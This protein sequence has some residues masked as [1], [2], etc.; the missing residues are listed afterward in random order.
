LEGDGKL[1]RGGTAA[2]N[3]LI[4]NG[5]EFI[6][7]LSQLGA[8]VMKV[9]GSQVSASSVVIAGGAIELTTGSAR[10]MGQAFMSGGKLLVS[11]NTDI[12]ITSQIFGTVGTVEKA[13]SAQ[14]FI[15]A[16]M[17]KFTG[18]FVVNGG[19][20]VVLS[21]GSMFGGSL[22]GNVVNKGELIVYANNYDYR[23]TL[24][25]QYTGLRHYGLAVS[26]STDSVINS[27]NFAFGSA[28]LN[29]AAHFYTGA[30]AN[31]G[32]S[33]NAAFR[34]EN[35]ILNNAGT[36]KMIFHDVNILLG[37]K[38]GAGSVSIAVNFEFTSTRT[39][40]DLRSGATARLS[41]SPTYDPHGGVV[42][43][44][45]L[46]G[47]L[48]GGTQLLPN[49]LGIGIGSTTVGGG[50]AYTAD[51]LTWSGS[52]STIYFTLGVE[53][54]PNAKLYYSDLIYDESGQQT[55]YTQKKTEVQVLG[56]K[57]SFVPLGGSAYG[58]YGSSTTYLH[59]NNLSFQYKLTISTRNASNIY[60]HIIVQ[61]FLFLPDDPLYVQ[62]INSGLG[63][64]DRSYQF[65]YGQESLRNQGGNLYRINHPYFLET[66]GGEFNV[67][68]DSYTDVDALAKAGYEP[69][70]FSLLGELHIPDPDNPW[71]RGYLFNLSNATTF[72]IWGITIA[73]ASQQSL[74]TGGAGFSGDGSVLRM[75]NAGAIAN[76]TDLI[77][78]DNGSD[79]WGGAVYAS[80][81]SLNVKTNQFDVIFSSNVA[82][83]GGAV[84]LTGLG[85]GRFDSMQGRDASKKISFSYNISTGVGSDQ[86]GGAVYR[87]GL[88]VNEFIGRVEFIG[89]RASGSGGAVYNSGSGSTVFRFDGGSLL[90]RGN[91]AGISGGAIFNGGN[92]VFE[93][94]GAGLDMIFE[95][96]R[97]GSVLND[98][99][100]IG[101]IEIIAVDGSG[102]IYIRSGIAGSG[103]LILGRG[104]FRL[105]IESLADGYL[106]KFIQTGGR[107]I[108][109]SAFFKTTELNYSAEF[110]GRI[111]FI[112][113]GTMTA[114][115]GNIMVA[116][117]A[118]I[119]SS[120]SISKVI[121]FW[122]G[123]ISGL[124]QLSNEGVGRLLI[125]GS[126]LAFSG[127]L[128][129]VSLGTSVIA[130]RTN[131]SRY[132]ASLGAIEF[133]NGAGGVVAGVVS[134]DIDLYAGG[135]LLFT[136]GAGIELTLSGRIEGEANSVI[137]KTG[138][139][140]TIFT[141]L[142][143]NF[144]GRII[145]TAGT[146]T[147]RSA[148]AAS[149]YAI[150]GGVLE[151]GEGLAE[152]VDGSIYLHSGGKLALSGLGDLLLDIPIYGQSNVGQTTRIEKTGSGAVV[153][154]Q[155]GSRFSGA[156]Y[157]VGG[158]FTS[159]F[160]FFVG[161][162]TVSASLLVLSG[163]SDVMGG[164]ITLIGASAG[165][166]GKGLLIDSD[167]LIEVR[168][169]LI[170]G[171]NNQLIRKAGD[172][173]SKF[174]ADNSLFKG[175]YVQSGDGE[176]A[177]FNEFGAS[178]IAV[179]GGNLVLDQAIS[180]IDG[181]IYMGIGNV[182]RIAATKAGLLTINGR[183]H[184]GQRDAAD[185][186]IQKLNVGVLVLNADNVNYIG[187]FRQ[188][189][190]RTVVSSGYFG[191]TTNIEGGIIE[192]TSAAAFGNQ[193]AV[194]RKINLLNSGSQ[195]LVSGW[196]SGLVFS[197]AAMLDGPSGS[198]FIKTS[199]GVVI[200]VGAF[201]NFAGNFD[202]GAGTTIFM[203]GSARPLIFMASRIDI[204]GGSLLRLDGRLENIETAVIHLN[205]DGKLHINASHADNPNGITLPG[206]IYGGSGAQIIKNGDSHLYLS[207]SGNNNFAGGYRQ[208]AG[209]TTLM[210]GSNY[211]VG[212]TT[213]AASRLVLVGGSGLS[214]GASVTLLNGGYLLLE[215]E[216]AWVL[217]GR[218]IA[219]DR[220]AGTIEKNMDGDLTIAGG[221]NLFKGL[222]IQSASGGRTVLNGAFDAIEYILLGGSL[223]VNNG[224]GNVLIGSATMSGGSALNLNTTGAN[225]VN[226][227]R[228]V[229]GVVDDSI[230][231]VG[232]SS[233]TF[234]STLAGFGG[235]FNI[236]GGTVTILNKFIRGMEANT[237]VAGALL[238]FV[239]G[240]ADLGDGSITLEGRSR[241]TIESGVGD[242]TFSG[243]LTAGVTEQLIKSANSSVTFSG[244]NEDFRGRY[245]Q[246]A[247]TT[248]VRGEFFNASSMSIVGSKL[249]LEGLL[250]GIS[251]TQWIDLGGSGI[252]ELNPSAEGLVLE[253]LSI[254][255]SGKAQIRK[256]GGNTLSM[257]GSNIG[258]KYSGGF[259][260][261]A[262]ETLLTG[263]FFVGAS[264]IAGGV[265]T[266]D[267]GAV[268]TGGAGTS[269]ELRTGGEILIVSPSPI[270]IADMNLI[271][272]RSG[273]IENI[274]GNIEFRGD[275][276]R[277]LG[278][279]VQNESVD[280]VVNGQFN[281]SS[282][283][284]NAGSLRT[285][286]NAGYLYADIFLA[287]DTELVIGNSGSNHIEIT[288]RIFGAMGAEINKGANATLTLSGFNRNFVGEFTQTAG[289]TTIR[290]KYFG[291]GSVSNISN[292]WL[293]IA[294]GADLGSGTFN[295]SDN[296]RLVIA[297]GAPHILFEGEIYDDGG[298]NTGWIYKN[299]VASVTFAGDNS[300]F[301]GRYEQTA[302]TTVIRGVSASPAVFGASV[303]D[304]KAGQLVIDDYAA[305]IAGAIK[306]NAIGRLW[307]KNNTSE[308]IVFAGP[309]SG[310]GRSL[311]EKTS[312][313]VL[314]LTGDNSG[315]SGIYEQRSGTTTLEAGR[316]FVG[317]STISGSLLDIGDGGMVTGGQ[318]IL[319]N[320]G[321]LEF[322]GSDNQTVSGSIRA[323]NL[324]AGVIEHTGAGNITFS[325]NNGVFK[326]RFINS[327]GA[328]FISNQ[329]GVGSIAI[330]N[331]SEVA[332]NGSLTQLSVNVVGGGIWMYGVGGILNIAAANDL[333]INGA[334]HGTAASEI[335]KAGVKA[336]ILI[337]DDSDFAGV[338]MQSAGTTVVRGKYF[339]GVSEIIGSRLEFTTGAVLSA[340]GTINLS[341]GGNVLISNWQGGLIFSGQLTGGQDT[342]ISKTSSGTVIFEG[343]GNAGFMGGYR[344]YAGTTTIRG[345]SSGAP[346]VFSAS[347]AYIS[348]SWL[349]Y[350]DY[351]GQIAGNLILASGKLQIAVNGVSPLTMS[352]QIS[353]NAGSEIIKTGGID[354]VVAG[355]NRS[356]LGGFR[357]SAGRTII[358]GEFF[359]GASTITA[360]VLVL[361]D[362]TIGG[363][364]IYLRGASGSNGIF[365][366]QNTV[367]R[368]I[369]G[370][371]HGDVNQLI[372]K[373]GTMADLEFRGDNSDF[374][375]RLVLEDNTGRTKLNGLMAASSIAVKAGSA[376]E[377]TTGA[378][379]GTMSSKFYVYG[380]MELT[381]NRDL[382]LSGQIFG[383]GMIVK[384]SSKT[385]SLTADNSGFIGSYTQERGTTVVSN[386][387]FG[388][389][390]LI[391]NSRLELRQGS[392]LG[393][394]ELSLVN[395]NIYIEATAGEL[396]FE[397][398]LA[399]DASSYILKSNISTLTF[400]GDNTNFHGR[401]VQEAGTTV[402]KSEGGLAAQMGASSIAIRSGLLVL[403]DKL[404]HFESDLYLHSAG[405]VWIEATAGGSNSSQD[406]TMA[407][408]IFGGSGSRI[409]KVGT[410]KLFLDGDNSGFK[411][412]YEQSAGTTVAR[413]KFFGGTSIIRSNSRLELGAGADIGAG[414]QID[415]RTGGNVYIN[416][417][418]AVT[419][420]ANITG[421]LG[422]YILKENTGEL[423]FGGASL[424][425]RGRLILNE[426]T[427][428]LAA[429]IGAGSVAVNAAAVLRLADGL[430]KLEGWLYNFGRV[431][432]ENTISHDLVISSAIFGL[433]VINKTGTAILS[434]SSANA[435][436]AGVY[437][438]AAGTIV[439]SNEFFGGTANIN[440]GYIH[441]IDGAQM[442][443]D[444]SV[445]NIG[446]SALMTMSAQT[447]VET[448][449]KIAG[450]GKIIKNGSGDWVLKNDNSGFSGEFNQSAGTTIFELGAK[451]F[452]GANKVSNNGV[453]RV[454]SEDGGMDFDIEVGENGKFEFYVDD[455]VGDLEIGGRAIFSGTNGLMIFGGLGTPY[456][457]FKI[458]SNP[459]GAAVNNEIK[460][461]KV[462][463]LVIGAGP[464][465]SGYA[466]IDLS[467]M[468]YTLED[469]GT[470]DIRAAVSNQNGVHTMTFS[471]LN[472][473]GQAALSFNL[474]ISPEGSSWGSDQL[475]IGSLT[476]GSGFGGFGIETIGLYYN[477]VS[478]IR[479]TNLDPYYEIPI[480][481]GAGY[482]DGSGW[483]DKY[484]G[485]FGNYSLR[486]TTGTNTKSVYI[487]TYQ[488]PGDFDE[489]YVYAR[490]S[491][492]VIKSSDIVGW[493]AWTNYVVPINGDFTLSGKSYLENGR[494]DP[495]GTLYS[496]F[497]DFSGNNHY[498]WTQN[499]GA[500]S[501]FTVR[502]L[503]FASAG[504]D[505]AVNGAVLRM[506]GGN[507]NTTLFEDVIVRDN[508]NEN[509]DGLGGALYFAAGKSFR[510][511]SKETTA[512]YLRNWA[513]GYGGAVAAA[514]TFSEGIEFGAARGA[515]YG[516]R[517][518]GNKAG[519]GGGAIYVGNGGE[520]KVRSFAEF[521]DNEAG[522]ASDDGAGGAVYVGA[523]G[524]FL[525]EPD[526]SSITFKRNYMYEG[527]EKILNDWH[528]EG[529]L[530]IVG[531]KG[532]VVLT[533]GISGGADGEIYHK[534]ET[535]EN[536]F[537]L[538]GSAERF[539]GLFISSGGVTQ[540][541]TNYFARSHISSGNVIFNDYTKIADGTTI[542]LE[543]F[544]ILSIN[545][546]TNMGTDSFK[547]SM[548]EA[549]SDGT[550]RKMNPQ[551]LALGDIGAGT[552]IGTYEHFNGRTEVLGDISALRRI[553][554]GNKASRA[555]DKLV[556]VHGSSWNYSGSDGELEIVD[557]GLVEIDN[558]GMV[559]KA[560]LVG[561]SGTLRKVSTGTLTIINV[562]NESRFRG[563][564]EQTAG[565]TLIDGSFGAR[566]LR[567]SGSTI[568]FIGAGTSHGSG[569][570]K[571]MNR[572]ILRFDLANASSVIDFGGDIEGGLNEK[573]LK[574]DAGRLNIMG[575]IAGGLRFT[576]EYRQTAGTTTVRG[577]FFSGKSYIEGSNV[578]LIGLNGSIPIGAIV[579]LKNG[580]R[581]SADPNIGETFN[582]LGRLLGG[583]AESIY[584]RG[585]GELVLD[586]FGEPV[587]ESGLAR[588][589]TGKFV[590]ENGT[591]TVKYNFYAS[592]LE[593]ANSALRLGSG[594]NAITGE[595]EFKDG[596]SLIIEAN[597]LVV[598]GNI[599]SES[600]GMGLIKKAAS[601]L[602][603]FSGDNS[604]FSGAFVS[605]RGT[606][607]ILGSFGADRLELNNGSVLVFAST[608]VQQYV[609]AIKLSGGSS[610]IVDSSTD[611]EIGGAIEGSFGNTKDILIKR[612][613]GELSL[614]G[615]LAGFEG[616][617][618]VEGGRAIVSGADDVAAREIFISNGSVLELGDS[619]GARLDINSA[620]IDMKTAGTLRIK[621][622]A[623]KSAYFGGET[624]IS[625]RG[626]SGREVIEN[627]GGILVLDDVGRDYDGFFRQIDGL[628]QTKIYGRFN[629]RLSSITVG[630][631]ELSSRAVVGD[632]YLGGGS[633]I[634]NAPDFAVI[635]GLS[636]GAAI[637]KVNVGTFTINGDG[638]K[639]IGTLTQGGGRVVMKGNFGGKAA[640]AAGS[641]LEINPSGIV[642]IGTITLSAGSKLEVKGTLQ[643]EA[644][645]VR[646]DGGGAIEKFGLGRLVL[647]GGMSDF[648]GGFNQTAG[649]TIVE[650]KFF[651]GISTVS[652]GSL[653]FKTSS[654]LADNSSIELREKASLDFAGSD[655]FAIAGSQI[656]AGDNGTKINKTGSGQLTIAD[657]SL[658]DFGG[659]YTHENGTTTLKGAFGASKININNRIFEFKQTA[660]TAIDGDIAIKKQGVLSLEAGGELTFNGAISGT[661][662]IV[663]NGGNIVLAADNS[664]WTGLFV[665]ET[666]ADVETKVRN[667]YFM[668]IS[669]IASGKL[670]FESSAKEIAAGSVYLGRA[671]QLNISTSAVIK[672]EIRSFA[673]GG[674]TIT[675]NKVGGSL[676]LE[677]DNSGFTG[678]FEQQD[679]AV[680]VGGAFFKG[681]SL[682]KGGILEFGQGSSI[683]GGAKIDLAAGSTMTIRGSNISFEAGQ[684]SGVGGI[685]VD[686]AGS[687]EIKGRQ[688]GW[689]GLLQGQLGNVH[690]TAGGI[691]ISSLVI[692]RSASNLYGRYSSVNERGQVSVTSAVHVE[693]S[694]VLNIG[695]DFS[696]GA[697]DLIDVS[698]DIELGYDL[699]IELGIYGKRS[700]GGQVLIIRSGELNVNNNSIVS[701]S[702]LAADALFYK[703]W[704]TRSKG[705]V[706]T[707]Q[708]SSASFGGR[709]GVYLNTRAS[710]DPL[711]MKGATHNE[712]QVF[713]AINRGAVDLDSPLSAAHE[714]MWEMA[715]RGEF[716]AL[717][718]AA[719]SLSGSFYSDIL[720]LPV[721]NDS[722][723]LYENIDARDEEGLKEPWAH[724]RYGGSRFA[725]NENGNGDLK[726][727]G[728]KL[729][730]GRGLRKG[731]NWTEGLYGSF[732]SNKAEQSADRAGIS[733]LEGGYWRAFYFGKTVIKANASL[734]LQMWDVRRNIEFMGVHP[735]SSFNTYTFKGGGEVLQPL[736]TSLNKENAFEMSVF[737]GIN[738]GMT[739]NGEIAERGDL[740]LTIEPGYY[741]KMGLLF[742]LRLDGRMSATKLHWF[743]KLFIAGLDMT[744]KGTYNMA[745]DGQGMH[746][747]EGSKK[748]APYAGIVGGADY[749]LNERVSLMSN[750]GINSG[751]NIFSY[752]FTVG[753]RVGF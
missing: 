265:L 399:G 50:H 628:A 42:R 708:L 302:G 587:Y 103:G 345:G 145:E 366:A 141:G 546:N 261:T 387:F 44:I 642:A 472:I 172:G 152:L 736:W 700:Y 290:N 278:K 106:G 741:A 682:V 651:N 239:G 559:I 541:S 584:K 676:R 405:K 507:G 26:L 119:A 410:V 314:A 155:D 162:S 121:Q 583:A 80:A 694:G 748:A 288:S 661:G 207:G 568:S 55:S 411:G 534:G 16:D 11:G 402:I 516:T 733:D 29:S 404:T 194:G 456:P 495:S 293:I 338:Y 640:V 297:N 562:A 622:T 543:G 600:L 317:F 192:F 641:V 224:L 174:Y 535:F 107:V 158:I 209:T 245:A 279:Y 490:E 250:T 444:S 627:V 621:M 480:F 322:S 309:V 171:D 450:G 307:I 291:I 129:N 459:A 536:V 179:F 256:V 657:N 485:P 388:G 74:N 347:A 312:S 92:L 725:A 31:R 335:N 14:L 380:L 56:G 479:F 542:K 237:T 607:R 745:Q 698:G 154:E 462:D 88:G 531:D 423:T 5:A 34:V 272:D 504:T 213:I 221:N 306:L 95:D 160:G 43:D 671:A 356:Y 371:I 632:V 374:R 235:S 329:I 724:I 514:G 743:G 623:G 727:S 204:R 668:G 344:Q 343:N 747:I 183:I 508:R 201:E 722:T 124:G 234:L 146:I 173:E 442:R 445:L 35:S 153:F 735:R 202:Q 610:L 494:R 749:K 475:N 693:V 429:D 483:S 259:Y 560:S 67:Y 407:G 635:S 513:S 731:D 36:N 625:N 390:S 281:A 670:N 236:S 677:G 102:D 630:V 378:S 740:G 337:G 230:N 739:R 175:V 709:Q 264:T 78:I 12:R 144:G 331:M 282:I 505:A 517:F 653:I 270:L 532:A 629:A 643:S 110:G 38:N 150:T 219:A 305:E 57:L 737:G 313:K 426:G 89:N 576:G 557:N 181:Q 232:A 430:T 19:S 614:S 460:F 249:V 79:R 327:G 484:L 434:L 746:E 367:A 425:F 669:S 467:G 82:A 108:V 476:V 688:D 300:R 3:T 193:A 428:K 545:M 225:F 506:T 116:Q 720:T 325:A 551:V 656:I 354:L 446:G 588:L 156:Y 395:G 336:L 491:M 596:G 389:G 712:D 84:Y 76:L 7:T 296:G 752:G 62:N 697:A 453:F 470:I 589:F 351:V 372:E 205:A 251:N 275:N 25:G 703:K 714:R 47:T 734:S 91:Q 592:S 554:V 271:S 550:L 702:A 552:F 295:L 533:G 151:L 492:D 123:T 45:T 611:T 695:V 626:G 716:G 673:I 342:Y 413:G 365:S 320:G 364:Q 683:L 214:A 118:V 100:S 319:K 269:L 591:T 617:F 27:G 598:S 157:Q 674:G 262:G 358:D 636:G 569:T 477:G 449:G 85:V 608:S 397:G 420:S 564:Y 566:E 685:L 593:I 503:T 240:R 73:S 218:I 238:R 292:S 48:L 377:I 24:N 113:G 4:R 114:A 582:V 340:A 212:A 616:I 590:S 706:Y 41:D 419:V 650:D 570:V 521:I 646:I 439:V 190:G 182:L 315:F 163:D 52:G 561:D 732:A 742:G 46:T 13:G 228:S 294:G 241:M 526:N 223:E 577:I 639:Y 266:I 242:I 368:I 346:I 686:R 177:I 64:A 496:G 565:L 37:L 369:A 690:M 418:S 660:A 717:R 659:I 60:Q 39:V 75:S 362:G 573:V 463:T 349:V 421:G 599:E 458:N 655:N 15:E 681:N 227:L 729:Q 310:S 187:G 115:G 488:L 22:A 341:L 59:L 87:A 634:V 267:E 454:K 469:V 544:G 382:S 652:G 527:G 134:G 440:G 384:R 283:A 30:I 111:E 328:A 353:G 662:R 137:R 529:V 178:S 359:R 373:V 298:S 401:F 555:G 274:G 254:V 53:D 689:D 260:Q 678:W 522:G 68:I 77:V 97:S 471:D 198:G 243:Q 71:S 139:G 597:N 229:S 83:S 383:D 497:N 276:R 10:L 443:T 321:R 33:A 409:D 65:E 744:S 370:G 571:L 524:R 284:I 222:F 461:S 738:A 381:G 631:L 691:K 285:A 69:S 649:E 511:L 363:G 680:L 131:I 451:V 379:G 391:R 679:G 664:G 208:N 135:A 72:N 287:A 427:T 452:G 647:A 226:V 723:V 350:E 482:F 258:I 433:G 538:R 455:S 665:Q 348:N 432:I 330:V 553:K 692:T 355:D 465:G 654:S 515:R 447:S 132:T 244:N 537:Y 510:S 567:I 147:V 333:T 140:R 500:V 167:G 98:I 601:G 574:T 549:D 149:S 473:V 299:S 416:N 414:A 481:T 112:D 326:G 486:V 199:T 81:G 94:A 606:T 604:N 489:I 548:I 417:N 289:T 751:Q 168:A 17:R 718:A 730:G 217:S 186:G 579:E 586:M 138:A 32:A 125:T 128:Q 696:K 18:G 750:V 509:V 392:V 20:V 466:D 360:S 170:S 142:N 666:A 189:Q 728:V 63:S 518:E 648:N 136:Q 441:F 148:I 203:G 99:Y 438:Q 393:D 1:T 612:N 667:N 49:V 575:D 176:S 710:I 161:N 394:A 316:F 220:A 197:S 117:N 594:V 280:A 200:F 547:M 252:L 478:G 431:D 263:R 215:L 28:N 301:N 713:G 400:L 58:S 133:T 493:Q 501:S 615:G 637:S 109:S 499:D 318:I 195:V 257:T 556:F 357:Q 165:D 376:L 705:M 528:I 126:N 54:E 644:G 231:K 185:D 412:E 605:E 406:L 602:L 164:T 233:V 403:G 143:D 435:G 273:V 51:K 339:S 525:I 595:I 253:S 308:Q 437:N 563:F 502:N 520:L 247:G 334:I 286:N 707:S 699:D 246:S 558:H 448:A 23:L 21:S 86:G 519:K 672:G 191:G 457:N 70:K 206:N 436:F 93:F 715:Q 580:G 386:N 572:A 585:V 9:E 105:H 61:A 196:A 530:E 487:Y 385:L 638:S 633:M 8:G 96:N 2:G 675:F 523:D 211:F 578:E 169:K 361:R 613:I 396:V 624:Q 721:E 90:F 619:A 122:D 687:L 711:I 304:I 415:L 352:G 726:L 539:E 104:D 375:G 620:Q 6:G 474:Y 66:E 719:A 188:E 210:S 323:D 180:R 498:L 277:Y 40:V 101:I 581:F 512:L 311:I 540:V 324:A 127:T 424:G 255:G 184:G 603:T 408:D 159:N 166:S 618:R 422:E 464:G 658:E 130:G 663:S 645:I 120:V 398:H 468:K 332:L 701:R 268:L 303:I 704:T 753:A 216:T 248:V 684:I 609:S